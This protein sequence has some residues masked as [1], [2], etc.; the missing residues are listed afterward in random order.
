MA[1]DTTPEPTQEIPYGYC[2]CGCGRKT[3]IATRNHYRLGVLKGEPFRYVRHH[4]SVTDRNRPLEERFWRRVDVGT[5][6]ECWMWTGQ[7]DTHGYGLLGSAFRDRPAYITMRAHR[8]SY[9]LAHGP[10]PAGMVVCHHCDNPSC[11]N[12]AHLF[13]GT[14]SDNTR[15][16]TAKKRQARGERHSQTRLTEDDVREIR[17]ALA[18]GET[19]RSIGERFGIHQTTVSNIATRITW[20]HVY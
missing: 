8:L 4:T 14:Q 18:A 3:K 16:M 15:D 7:R 17:S 10:I 20:D 6:D 2:H 1:H 11:V 5:P 12:P 9:E 19:Q 13:L